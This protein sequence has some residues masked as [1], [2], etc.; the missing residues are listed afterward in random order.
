[1]ANFVSSGHVRHHSLRRRFFAVITALCTMVSASVSAASPVVARSDGPQGHSKD[2]E[3]PFVDNQRLDDVPYSLPVTLPSTKMSSAI[4]PAAPYTPVV[5]SLIAQLE[6]SNPPTQ[7]ELANAAAILHDGSPSNF[8]GGVPGCYGTGPVLAPTGTMPSI[9]QMCWADA[10][11]VLL[12]NGAIQRGTTAPMTLMGLGSTFDTQL[13]NVWGQTAATEARWY[14]VTGMYGPQG[15]IDVLPNWG[16]NLTTT[17]EDPYL[18]RRTV[19]AQVNG[20]QGV[21][22]MSQMKHFAVYNGQNGNTTYQ[23]QWLH[24]MGLAP[25]EGGYVDGKAAAAMCSYQASQDL[26][27]HLPANVPT[28]W[29]TSPFQVGLGPQTWPLNEMHFSCEQPLLLNYVLR[30][31]WGS[32][33]MVASDYGAQHSASAIFQGLDQEMPSKAYYGTLNPSNNGGFGVSGLD[34]TGDVCSDASGNAVSCTSPSAIL[35]AGIPSGAAC[36]VNASTGGG[37]GLVNAV[38]AGTVPLSVFNQ[39]L[40]RILYQEERFGLLGCSQKPVSQLCT[41][42]GGNGGRSG[43]QPGTGTRTGQVLLPDG[44]TSGTPVLGTKNGDAA[45]VERFSEE[46]AVLLKNEDHILPIKQSDL[47]GGILITGANANHTVADPTSEASTGFIDRD[48]I[49]PMQQLEAYAALFRRDRDEPQSPDG[50]DGTDGRHRSSDPFTFVPA[51]DPTGQAVPSS[52]L[53]T[54]NS[55]VTGTLTQLTASGTTTVSSL[56]YTTT[57]GKGQLAPGTYTWSGNVYV[58]STD[59]YTF[60]FES[61]ASVPK[62]NITFSFDGA[63]K[64][65]IDAEN[66]YGPT[67]PGTPTNVGYIEAGLSNQKCALPTDTQGGGGRGGPPPTPYPNPCPSNLVGGSFHAIT[68]SFNNSAG[69]PASFR[70]A[71]SRT[72]GDIADAAAAAKGKKMAVVFVNDGV[73]ATSTV[74]NPSGGG[75]ISSVISL[76]PASNDLVSAVAAAN[77]NTVVVLNTA[78]P[79]LLPWI[80]NVKGVLSMWFAGQEGGTSTARLLLGLANPSGHTSITWPANPTDTIWG[81]NETTPLYP[82]DTTGQHPERYGAG[83]GGPGG[84]GSASFTQGIYSGYRF[85]DKEGIAPLFAFGHGLSYSTFKLSELDIHR[86]GDTVRV[87]FRVENSGRLAGTAVP[88][89]YVGPSSGVPSSIQQAVH[90]LQGFTRVELRPDESKHVEITLDVRA[91]QYW[92][93]QSQS[94][95]AAPGARTITVGQSSRDAE[96]LTGVGL[97]PGH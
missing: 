14:M 15:D 45:I 81:Y 93:E 92:D 44:P 20:L 76:S 77:P 46:G 22:A 67:V 21:G 58:P 73:G 59:T 56:D 61:S 74:A 47:D 30:D 27:T 86:D 37:C 6:P 17:G 35:V 62:S 95:V 19:A 34:P 33:A 94:W 7:A 53:S 91:F 84:G 54:S 97:P 50:S 64:N 83:G 89:V 68:I 13:G 70:F 49:N 16:R 40:A 80:K 4:D 52:A 29:P 85:F 25:Y 79:V 78:N 69:A 32:H 26:A 10:Q 39:A 8:G 2:N 38:L 72:N 60:R 87:G 42:P 9:E 1:M 24:E 71:Y 90:S 43:D 36:P 66:V 82:G 23:D 63:S 31:L 5:L 41:N 51:N 55:S 11:G 57:S 18:S 28:L 96:A 3:A 12:T 65:V 88:Q 75:N 48:A